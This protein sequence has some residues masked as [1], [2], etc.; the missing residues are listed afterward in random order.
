MKEL[1]EIK[2]ILKNEMPHMDYYDI[3]KEAD[4]QIERLLRAVE[5]MAEALSKPRHDCAACNGTGWYEI[6]TGYP[7]EFGD[8]ITTSEYCDCMVD[9]EAINQVREVLK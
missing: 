2:H 1:E 3:R 6:G 7:S 8:E 9:R 4:F 5:I